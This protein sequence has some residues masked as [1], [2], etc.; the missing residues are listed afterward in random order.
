MLQR[1]KAACKMSTVEWRFALEALALICAVRITLAVL[2]FPKAMS[3]LGLH[4]GQPAS[5][6]NDIGDTSTQI[7]AVG[8]AVQR[9]AS[10]SPLKAVCLQQ[11]ATVAIMLRRRGLQVAVYFGVATEE[12]ILMAH[13]WSVSRGIIITG[14]QKTDRFVPITVYIT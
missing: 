11:A 10:V 2:P 8:L 14:K 6:I 3:C 1:I 9:A 12:G 4:Q 5:N 13:A 7:T